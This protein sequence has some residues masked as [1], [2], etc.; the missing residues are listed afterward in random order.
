MLVAVAAPQQAPRLTFMP[1]L[2]ARLSVS[3]Y[4]MNSRLSFPSNIQPPP[5]PLPSVCVDKNLPVSAKIQQQV[6]K[7]DL[8]EQIIHRILLCCSAY[9]GSL[10]VDWN[11]DPCMPMWVNETLQL[12]QV[13]SGSLAYPACLSLGWLPHV[14]AVSIRRSWVKQACLFRLC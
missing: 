5:P 3:S 14:E 8:T 11:A 1:C 2:P 9:S 4:H 12:T 6:E 13:V 10:W 7:G